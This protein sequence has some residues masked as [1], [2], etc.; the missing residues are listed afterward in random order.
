MQPAALGHS[1]KLDPLLHRPCIGNS[2]LP[3][4]I[5]LRGTNLASICSPAKVMLWEILLVFNSY[6]RE[7]CCCLTVSN[8]FEGWIS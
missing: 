8:L 4:A 7:K 2:W 3:Q 6:Q 1:G 5:V